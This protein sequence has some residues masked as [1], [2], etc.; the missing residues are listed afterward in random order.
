METDLD[1]VLTPTATVRVVLAD[2]HEL[3]RSGIRALLSIID[4]VEVVAEADDGQELLDRLAVVSADLV[5]TDLTMPGK[6]GMQAI[7]AM[8]DQHPSVR[9]IVLSMDMS[10]ATAREAFAK[11]ASGYIVKSGATAEL[12]TAIQAVMTGRRYLSP[13][14]ARAMLVPDESAPESRLTARQIE[15]VKLI[16]MGNSAREIGQQLGLSPKTVDAHRSRIME[17]LQIYDI[18][19]LTRYALRHRLVQ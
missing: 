12:S 13:V 15:I 4:G 5:M 14:V 17:K 11:G 10:A 18:A 3:V 16:A 7:E 9:I 6:D 19:G 8:H 1:D 2:D